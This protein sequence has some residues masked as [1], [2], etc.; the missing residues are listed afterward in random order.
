MTSEAF[1]MLCEQ[2]SFPEIGNGQLIQYLTEPRD[3][4]TPLQPGQTRKQSGQPR[5]G[6]VETEYV[7]ERDSR[8]DYHASLALEF[9]NSAHA[10]E[11]EQRVRTCLQTLAP[12][13]SGP[14][15]HKLEIK[16]LNQEQ[17]NRLPPN[18][19]PEIRPIDVVRYGRANYQAY[20][21]D[22]TCPEIL[23]EVMHLFGLNDEYYENEHLYCRPVMEDS[24]MV[25]ETAF[26]E[27]VIPT[28]IRCDCTGITCRS[29]MNSGN[30]RL[31]DAYTAQDIP[32]LKQACEWSERVVTSLSAP[33][34]VANGPRGWNVQR[35]RVMPSASAPYYEIR[36]GTSACRCKATDRYC[37]EYRRGDLQRS[38]AVHQVKAFCPFGA[39][40]LERKFVSATTPAGVDAQGI[41]S[42]PIP[43]GR[44][45]SLL[46]PN[47]F[48][49]V[50][51][52]NCPNASPNYRT[53]SNFANTLPNPSCETPMACYDPRY[54]LG[55]SH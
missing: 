33:T 55:T 10:A 24:L 7:M 31:I 32:T 28:Q 25:S 13:L 15:G 41:Y 17:L 45:R 12:Y 36:R 3:S 35:D 51:G 40:L 4:C 2:N 18:L 49:L 39:P 30:Q 37:L 20:P 9:P 42:F 53:C 52:G 46:H 5:G 19:R 6:G 50:I 38:R 48:R 44:N 14:D 26:T 22:I 16:L 27:S 47:Q 1:A 8:G 23:H 21:N 54:Y 34:F 11:V 43:Q 29:I